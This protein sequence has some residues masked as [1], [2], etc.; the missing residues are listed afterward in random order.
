MKKLLLQLIV[1]NVIA[2]TANAQFA[3]GTQVSYLQGH[4]GNDNHSALIGATVYGKYIIN[5]KVAIGNVIHVYG[6]KKS[7]Y[8]SGNISYSATD[9]VTN[10]ASTFDVLMGNKNSPVQ[11]YI[12]ADIGIS[13]SGHKVEYVNNKN[14]TLKFNIKQTYVMFSP[15]MGV[16]V[17]LTNMIGTFSQVQY[18]FSPG[19]GGPVKINLTGPKGV[20]SVLTTEPVSKYFNVD[21]GVYLLIGNIKQIL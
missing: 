18:N 2:L 19:D 12:G 4:G 16:N 10:V 14:Q 1:M 17:A 20:K 5:D 21:M 15:K 3:V 13:S 11:P 8:K 7:N 9:N 6:P